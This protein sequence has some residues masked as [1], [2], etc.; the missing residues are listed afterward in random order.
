MF[1]HLCTLHATPC[2]LRT[3]HFLMYLRSDIEGNLGIGDGLGMYTD[4]P[5]LAPA[6]HQPCIAYFTCDARHLLT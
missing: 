5:I 1:Y 6:V 3:V 4:R 2:V